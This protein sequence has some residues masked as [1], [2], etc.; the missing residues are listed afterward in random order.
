MEAQRDAGLMAN[1]GEHGGRAKTDGL[2]ENPSNA[3]PTLSE[4]GID[5][6]LADRARK[7]EAI[8]LLALL[9]SAWVLP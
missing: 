6:N 4:A 1:G 8:A 9:G 2:R 3:N 5:K 7:L